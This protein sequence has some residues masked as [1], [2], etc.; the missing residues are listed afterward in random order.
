MSEEETRDSAGGKEGE[1]PGYAALS[2][3]VVAASRTEGPAEKAQQ[4]SKAWLLL[5][6]V[7][8]AAAAIAW[9]ASVARN[10]HP[11][12]AAERRFQEK[13]R[14]RPEFTSGLILRVRYLAGNKARLD[15]SPRAGAADEDKRRTLREATKAVMEIMMEERPGRDLYIDAYQSEA[16]IAEAQYRAKSTLVS[17]DRKAQADIVVMFAGEEEG[18]VNEMLSRSRSV[19]GGR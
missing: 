6:V 2:M 14:A 16:Q 10:V 8:A 7:L 19:G 1:S 11:G 5:I 13:V 18:G 3:N 15:F 4:P 9:G 12:E 17:P